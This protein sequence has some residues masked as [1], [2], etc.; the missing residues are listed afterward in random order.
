MSRTVRVAAAAAV[1]AVGALV[2]L[3]YLF[4]GFDLA[5]KADHTSSADPSAFGGR[6]WVYAPAA[7]GWSALLDLRS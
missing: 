3:V 5:R 7:G 2:L 6:T 4:G 1:A